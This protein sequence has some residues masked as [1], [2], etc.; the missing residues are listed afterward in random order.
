M[1]KSRRYINR[2]YILRRDGYICGYCF[3]RKATQ[4]DHIIPVAYAEMNEESNLIACCCDCNLIAGSKVFENIEAKRAYIQEE[5]KTRKWEER[6]ALEKIEPIPLSAVI[7]ED[8]KTKV[9]VY[10]KKAV[11]IAPV[12]IAFLPVTEIPD[13]VV[14]R[15]GRTRPKHGLGIGPKKRIRRSKTERSLAGYIEKFLEQFYFENR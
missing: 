2:E 3:E 7:V 10:A 8:H 5:L 4:V 9:A 12:R 11:P 15:K 1:K 6:R 14:A 13:W